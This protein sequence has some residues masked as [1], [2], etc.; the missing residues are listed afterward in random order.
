MAFLGFE[1]RRFPVGTH[2]VA[3]AAAAVGCAE[4]QIVKS[5]VVRRPAAGEPVLVA[6]S[7]ANRLDLAKVAALVGEEVEMAPAKWVREITGFTIGGVPPAGHPV[8]MDTFVDEDL[9]RYDEVWASAGTPFDVFAIAPDRLV[10]LTGGRVA[11]V[12]E[13]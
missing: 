3:D 9:L 5:L 13:R 7:G 6:V 1:T 10:E 4:A 11:D 12:A 8:A 2:S